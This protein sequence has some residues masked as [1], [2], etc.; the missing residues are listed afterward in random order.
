[1]RRLIVRVKIEDC[2]R[3]YCQRLCVDRS[4]TPDI[5]GTEP[6]MWYQSYVNRHL[7]SSNFYKVFL[8]TFTKTIR[9]RNRAWTSYGSFVHILQ[10][11]NATKHVNN[12]L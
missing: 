8:V 10:D 2:Y 7:L 11:V 9:T 5:P 3:Y 4:Y 6:S 12:A 1:M